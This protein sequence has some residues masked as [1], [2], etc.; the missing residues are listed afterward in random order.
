[1]IAVIVTEST[2][3]FGSDNTSGPLRV[4]YQALF[5][6]VT[7]DRWEV[8]HHYIRK[9]GHF[10]GYGLVGLSWLRAWRISRT[11]WRFRTDAVLALLATAVIASAD[12]IHQSFLPNRTSTPWDVALDC[13]GAVVMLLIS[14]A[15]LRMWRPRR[16]AAA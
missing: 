8:I 10:I 13:C 16:L 15:L 14:Y 1:M 7:D 5:G 3:T 2:Q 9:S 6:H 11:Q 12:E 4:A